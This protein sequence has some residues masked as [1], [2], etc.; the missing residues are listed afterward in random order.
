MGSLTRSYVYPQAVDIVRDLSGHVL[1]HSLQFGTGRLL[2]VKAFVESE[3]LGC[4]TMYPC[5]HE[6]VDHEIQ[7]LLV[8]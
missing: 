5:I 4:V 1:P 6:N 2:I 7:T 3:K 8:F